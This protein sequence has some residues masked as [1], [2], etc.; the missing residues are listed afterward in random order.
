MHSEQRIQRLPR[1][2]LHV[3]SLQWSTSRFAI[4]ATISAV[5]GGISLVF[6]YPYFNID[7]FRM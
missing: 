2:D 5:I 1:P 3:K 4:I 6:V 7:R